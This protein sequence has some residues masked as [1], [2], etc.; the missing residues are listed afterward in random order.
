MAAPLVLAS[1]STIRAQL[2]RNAG[3]SFEVATARI[4]E[5]AITAA[6]VAEGASPRDIADALAEMK[7]AKVAAR[8][9][10]A[11]VI[12]ADQVLAL[13]RQMLSKP[14]DKTQAIAQLHHM[15]G[16]THQL[17]SAAVIYQDGQPQWRHVGVVRL[18]MRDATDAYIAGYVDRNWD[19]IRHCVGAYQ[20]EHEGVRLFHK[21]DGDFFHVM[22]LPLLE[23]LSYLT[24]R[25]TIEG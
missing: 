9:P 17:L 10:E 22:G 11:M 13:E 19:E 1:G 23:V 3:L 15:R 18:H 12:G 16:K 8:H 21:V 7:A 5:E 4:D 6:L 25:G 20:L 2:L 14:N 24:L